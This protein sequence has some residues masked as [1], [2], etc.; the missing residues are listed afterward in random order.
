MF[1]RTS[2]FIKVTAS[3]K[4]ISVNLNSYKDKVVV[5]TNCY[6]NTMFGYS[7]SNIFNSKGLNK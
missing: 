5:V 4:L 7:T 3:S 1:L 6:L 2:R